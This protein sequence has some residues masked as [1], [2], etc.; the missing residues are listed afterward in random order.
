MRNSWPTRIS[1]AVAL[2]CVGASIALSAGGA[3]RA[4][5][6]EAPAQ[7]VGAGRLE[8][9]TVTAQFREQKAQQTPLAITAVSADMLE[10]RSETSIA[11][12]AAQ[13]PNV[14][15]LQNA[16]AFG[17]SLGASIRGVGQFDFS[18]ALEPGVGL[19][20]DD[21][22]YATLTGS[23]FD[24]LDLDHVEILRG[25]QGTLAGRNSIGGAVKLYSTKPSE[26]QGGYVSATY[27]SRDRV[28]IRASGDFKVSDNLFA[29]IAAVSKQ[30]RGYVAD[31]DYGC[32]HPNSGVA[33]VRSPDS[34]CVL[35]WEGGVSYSAV[36]GSL[37]WLAAE[38]LEVNAA[39]DYT[40][41]DHTVPGEV[42]VQGSTAVSPNAQPVPG[43][44]TALSAANFQTPYG[45]YYNYAT[46][47][48][49]AGTYRYLSGPNVGKTLPMD[50]DSA[51]DRDTFDGWGASANVDWKISD[52]LSLKSITAYRSYDSTF[53]NDNDLSPLGSS[54]GHGV[55]DFHSFSE[56]VRLNG[57]LL[58]DDIIEYTVGA[59]YMKDQTLYETT[60]DLRYSGVSFTQ[61]QGHD[62]INANTQAAFAHLSYHAT[63]KLTLNAGLRYTDEHKDYTFSRHDREGDVPPAF[64]SINGVTTNYD[65]HK[66]DWRANVEYQWTPLVMTYAQVSTGFKGG[67]VSPRPFVA[68][69]AVPFGPEDMTSYEA[70]VKSDLFERHVRVN[71]SAFF[72]KYDNIQ[73]TLSS[74]PQYGVGLP[75]GVVANAGDAHMKGLEFETT[76]RPADHLSIDAAV[77]YLDFT[78]TWIDPSVGAGGPA[79]GDYP[80]YTPRFKWNVGAQYE[81]V[82]GG[83]GSLTPRVDVTYQGETYGNANDAV[84][85]FISS[86]TLYNAR[87]TWRNDKDTWEAALEG[88]NLGNKYYFI[89]RFDQ[90]TTTGVTEGQPGR[91]REWAI[92]VKRRF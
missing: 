20:V 89:T 80:A 85:S 90:Y 35:D 36:R 2:T 37:R 56:E 29:R 15:L 54:F 84:T 28:D 33:A 68:A 87:L 71:L 39:L 49:P 66:W 1:R 67:G 70:G 61:F 19:Y 77:S 41:D 14:T 73:E 62:P 91:P 74:C 4:I 55:L 88:T 27:G 34:G 79:Y 92:T 42:L 16:A 23:I 60:Q 7:D 26:D 10:A 25:P 18:P 43:G 24:L 59:F 38:N 21:V 12:V 9:V 83:R 11:S 47:Y 32:D 8:E 51:P 30:Q 31:V 22:Y 17:D 46:F 76:F 69:Q 3:G 64:A 58:A 45:S 13:A 52:Q 72:S 63:D 48:S 65:G 57:A 5:A 6:Q 78:Y 53:S 40:H 50:A 44:P 82:L 75:C 86:Y 81:V